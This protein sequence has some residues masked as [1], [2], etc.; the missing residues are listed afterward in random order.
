MT[1]QT[2]SPRTTNSRYRL[3]RKLAV[4]GMATVYLADDLVLDRPVALKV[5]LPTL[6]SDPAS[7]T[8]SAGKHSLRGRLR[9]PSIV[10]VYDWGSYGES[11]CI[12]MEYVEGRTLD[13]IIAEDGPLAPAEAARI[14]A[15]VAEAL[16]A[17]HQQGLVHRDVKPGNIMNTPSGLVKITDFGIARAARN[18]RD[19]T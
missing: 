4:G 14:A 8:V 1:D 2:S 15:G 9:H 5:L 11:Y 6:A 12:A 7:S 19:L 3:H 17:A 13:E 16:D 10:A 18:D